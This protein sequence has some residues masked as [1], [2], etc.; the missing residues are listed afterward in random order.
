MR[1]FLRCSLLLAVMPLLAAPARPA[2]PVPAS[3]DEF[4]AA[5][6]RIVE[7]AGL[8]G[9]GLALVRAGGIEWAGGIGVADRDTGRPIG[10][11]KNLAK[12]DIDRFKNE[13]D[14]HYKALE[15]EVKTEF[16]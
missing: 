12:S 11:I 4:K 8:P 9:A 2:D 6:A 7:E 14:G 15:R 16:R 10:A 3:L 5:A 1:W 13:R